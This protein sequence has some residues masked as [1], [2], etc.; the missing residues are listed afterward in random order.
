MGCGIEYGMVRYDMAWG[1]GYGTIGY[2]TAGQLSVI[3]AA[4]ATK[5]EAP[6][7]LPRVPRVSL[8]SRAYLLCA[9]TS[10]APKRRILSGGNIKARPLSTEK[11][12]SWYIFI[13]Y[14]FVDAIP[15]YLSFHS[16]ESFSHYLKK[17]PQ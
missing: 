17:K 7:V 4:A 12:Y 10:Q 3:V 15:G 2:G 5:E 13:Q 14:V 16:R 9:P 1:M 6:A 11:Q 8:V